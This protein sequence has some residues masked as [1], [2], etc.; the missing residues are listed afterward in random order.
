MPNPAQV[1]AGFALQ[2]EWGCVCSFQPPSDP[3]M[4]QEAHWGSFSFNF[5]VSQGMLTPSSSPDERIICA[6]LGKQTW[7]VY[8]AYLFQLLLHNATNTCS[9]SPSHTSQQ[10]NSARLLAE[11][12]CAE[13]HILTEKVT[14]ALAKLSTPVVTNTMNLPRFQSHK[15]F[16]T[17]LLSEA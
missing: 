2:G 11:C 4:S 13:Q 16:C 10:V 14:R 6:R 3:Q 5:P 15:S 8:E 17:V 9:W 1:R 12:P 7:F